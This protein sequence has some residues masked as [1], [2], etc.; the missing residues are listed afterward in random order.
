MLIP[1]LEMRCDWLPFSG[2]EDAIGYN[3]QPQ[4]KRRPFLAIRNEAKL[5]PLFIINSVTGPIKA[6]VPQVSMLSY[7]AATRARLP[8]SSSVLVT[9]C[10]WY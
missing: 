9:W 8:H 2:T 6:R 10:T 7:L 1:S 5:F 3:I 4:A